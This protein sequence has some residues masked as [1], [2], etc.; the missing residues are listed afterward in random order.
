MKTTTH[1]PG[2]WRIRGKRDGLI[3][4]ETVATAPAGYGLPVANVLCHSYMQDPSEAN[5]MLIAAAPELL[6]ACKLVLAQHDTTDCMGPTVA[7]D[8]R[9][10]V[11]KATGTSG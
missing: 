2:P 10:A 9:A 7:A 5:A 1:T 6:E 3:T 8:V 11:Q 4:V